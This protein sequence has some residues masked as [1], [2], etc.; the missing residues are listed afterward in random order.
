[1]FEVEKQRELPSLPLQPGTR[2][3]RLSIA[4]Y[5]NHPGL[6]LVLATTQQGEVVLELWQLAREN[7]GQVVASL[8][9]PELEGRSAGHASCNLECNVDRLLS[10]II[11]SVL[12]TGP[13]QVPPNTIT[14]RWADWGVF[15]ETPVLEA[16]AGAVEGERVEDA[17]SCLWLLLDRQGRR[18][19]SYGYQTGAGG[20]TGGVAEGGIGVQLGGADQQSPGCRLDAGALLFCDRAG[21]RLDW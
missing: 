18:L 7:Y 1:M 4:S 12:R 13:L 16:G 19:C 11:S 15:I 21:P 20:R 5:P 9:A 3:L 6:L 10:T 14:I 8:P 2:L 17:P